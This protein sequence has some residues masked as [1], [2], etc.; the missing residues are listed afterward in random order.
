MLDR[1]LERPRTSVDVEVWMATVC[2]NYKWLTVSKLVKMFSTNLFFLFI[3]SSEVAETL[4]Q[5]ERLKALL[6]KR[7]QCKSILWIDRLDDLWY[8]LKVLGRSPPPPPLQIQTPSCLHFC[9]FPS[10]F[11]MRNFPMLKCYMYLKISLN[12]KIPSE[13]S[14]SFVRFL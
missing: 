6:C 2:V 12:N 3:F 9:R 10:I 1:R 14:H 7:E 13:T 4:L 8:Q 5:V 11:I